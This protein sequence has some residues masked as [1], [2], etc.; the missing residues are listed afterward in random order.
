[1][2]TA[3]A[4][5]ESLRR[6]RRIDPSLA[7]P[8]AE[9]LLTAAVEP[10]LTMTRMSELC[11]TSLATNSR[12]IAHLGSQGALG[13][14]GLG[15]ILTITD[16]SNQATTL[17]YDANGQLLSVVSPPAVSGGTAQTQSFTYNA[18]GD[19]LTVSTGPT[20]LTTYTYDSNG[21]VLTEL[22]K[23]GNTITRTYGSNFL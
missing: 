15:L 3:A 12:L 5:L 23:A 4:F 22:D 14:P 7:N 9:T 18:N 17:S 8:V 10:K 2:S 1:M 6:M 11:G 16:P 20:N 13:K 21:N 19:V